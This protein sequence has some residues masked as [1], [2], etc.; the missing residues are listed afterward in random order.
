MTKYR[1]MSH[2]VFSCD[3]HLVWPT[4][5]RREILNPGIQA[6]LLEVL[7][8]LPKY[9]PEIIIKEVNTDKDHIHLLASI[10]PTIAVGSV[11]RIIKTN[12]ANAL[13]HKFPHLR[14]VYWGSRSIWSA[15][16]FVSTVGINE[17]LIRRYIQNQGLEDAG[18]TNL[19]L[20]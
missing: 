1:R 20:V 9:R 4:K 18:Q 5:Y 14:E 17:E 11:V 16:Y 8:E 10:P 13:N 3:Y 2:F 15:G 19:E 7:K 6:Y 12:S